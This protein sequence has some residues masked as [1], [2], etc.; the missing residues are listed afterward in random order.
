M[1]FLYPEYLAL[2]I[3]LFVFSYKNIHGLKNTVHIFILI[4]LLIAL[5]RPV[6]DKQEQDTIIKG[7]DILIALDISYSMR[8]D[9]FKPTR[10]EYAKEI[11]KEVLKQNPNDNVML[12]VFTT[13][14]LLLS[15]PTTDHRLIITALD[16]LNIEYI[17]TKGTSLLTLFKKLKTI[18]VKQKNM[19]LITDGGEEDDLDTLVKEINYQTKSFTILAMGDN[20]G[21][22]IT[23]KD[24]TLLKDSQGSLVISRVNPILK[25]LSDK[26][27]AN[28]IEVL[29]SAKNSAKLLDSKL[30]ESNE[31][32]VKKEYKYIDL[33]QIPLFIA[34]ILFLMLHTKAVKYLIIL[35][36]LFSLNL[37]AS[38]IDNYYLDSAYKNYNL[39]DYNNTINYLKKVN[40]DTLESRII[41]A[42]TH[43]KLKNYQKALKIYL[44][45]QSSSIEIKKN[46][47]YNIANCFA[48]L[49]NFKD[50]KIFYAKV[51]QI[52]PDAD[53]LHNLKVIIFK[54]NRASKGD[55]KTMPKSKQKSSNKEGEFKSKNKN[56]LEKQKQDNEAKDTKEKYP[57]S[58][59]TYE[60]INEGYIDEQK[61]W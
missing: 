11:V 47:Y 48:S 1:S 14:P 2:I 50:A 3:A 5:S 34:A 26:V 61:P 60:L 12:I 40:N 25:T 24:G 45:I 23:K 13:N 41:E 15:P 46:I 54:E 31:V 27:D 9:D 36:A 7:R 17:L 30:K 59:K 37:N 19:I 49:G 18:D 33:Y 53:A 52:A 8:A 6:L 22:T 28:Y 55:G 38:I 21:S 4:L 16:A 43:Y 51:L 32:F 20:S 58:S 10:Y 29:A 39:H 57:I 42:N 35:L 56:T 44:S